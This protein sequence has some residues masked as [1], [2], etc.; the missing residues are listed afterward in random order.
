M[1]LPSQHAVRIAAPA[2]APLSKARKQ[3]NTLVKR[4]ETERAR[5]ALWHDE[6]PKIRAL[7]DN[8]LGPLMDAID[9]RQRALVELLHEAWSGKAMSKRDR[10]KLSDIICS[11]AFDLM[12]AGRSDDALRA[13][14][15]RHS[16]SH[17]DFGSAEDQAAMREA[18][19]R[20]T[21]I[22][23]DDDADLS[24][25][26]A[27]LEAMRV[28][29]AQQMGEQLGMKEE[30]EEQPAP[31][32]PAKVSA[33][34]ARH[35]AEEAK[36]KQSVR[37]IFRKLASALHPDRETDPTE[38]VRKTG[39]MQRA[40][41]AYAANDL[42]G[43]LEL[44][45]A[46]EQI[47][48]ASLD[49]LSDDRIK[50]YNKILTGQVNDVKAELD[51]MEYGITMEMGWDFYQ[52]PTL[53]HMTASLHT[54]IVRAR[55]HVAHIDADLATLGDVKK[56]KTWLKNYRIEQASPDVDDFFF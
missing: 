25:P 2:A 35:Q 56:L 9:T 1:P 15:E 17:L 16:T 29:M 4:L 54:D 43:L 3:F 48:Q 33:R 34:E 46:V 11:I 40:N 30:A 49:G 32:R 7:A 53:K 6:L 50:Q 45:L 21:G 37:D 52:R 5:L 22:T 14:V 31:A 47:D 28:K 39:L 26:A 8:E 12:D 36:L 23:L 44:Q 20:E 42:L 55:A 27:M 41:V 24:S 10:E 18:L 19:H 38:R 51:A 13:I